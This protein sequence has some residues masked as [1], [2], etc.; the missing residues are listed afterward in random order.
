VAL[1]PV[2]GIVQSGAQAMADR[3]SYVP[4]IGILV[5]LAW[6]IAD[7]IDR[8]PAARRL[9][10]LAAVLVSI[11]LAVA[12]SRQLGLWRSTTALF[13]HSTTASADNFQAHTILATQALL[14][15]DVEAARPH[16][17][18]AL[19][20]RPDRSEVQLAMGNLLLAQE[21]PAQAAPYLRR[22]VELNPADPDA[23][24]ALGFSLLETGDGA[25]AYEQYRTAVRLEPRHVA[26]QLHLAFL[27]ISRGR[28]RDALAHLEAVLREDPAHPEA[29]QA[30]A[31]VLRR[32]ERAGLPP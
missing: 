25:A 13:T 7:G 19:R 28:E 15:G 18:A 4:T 29:R 32:L 10:A 3:F 16:A 22:A 21:R 23:R 17:A 27:S 31:D 8:A 20:I 24:V 26:A 9:A 6:S 5:G 2:I 1:V 11:A 14:A 30:R 12:S